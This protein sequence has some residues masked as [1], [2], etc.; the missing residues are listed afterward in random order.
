MES[1]Q[2]QIGLIVTTNKE[3]IM[4]PIFIFLSIYSY[5]IN[6]EPD[7]FK[8][9][10]LIANYVEADDSSYKNIVG[11]WLISNNLIKIGK[12]ED[13]DLPSKKEIRRKYVNKT[14][15]IAEDY[16]I[17]V[18]DKSRFFYCDRNETTLWKYLSVSSTK[19]PNPFPNKPWGTKIVAYEFYDT[20]YTSATN[21]SSHF[22]ESFF[23][24]LFIEGK[25]YLYMG[26]YFIEII[27]DNNRRQNKNL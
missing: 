19:I 2:K 1:I 20:T 3:Y 25:Y 8:K 10:L 23:S 7:S 9:N 24:L 14:V 16:L 18:N 13:M 4:I 17:Q 15:E 21:P 22:P 26:N 27:L 6:K 11:K 5:N 12:G